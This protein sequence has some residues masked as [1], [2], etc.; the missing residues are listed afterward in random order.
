MLLLMPSQHSPQ[1]AAAWRQSKRA[2]HSQH[3]HLQ[4]SMNQAP[5]MMQLVQLGT[6]M[7][8]LVLVQ[9]FLPSSCSR[10]QQKPRK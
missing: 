9:L 4:R 10:C 5:L 6:Q 3:L 1:P 7:T 2:C 8:N